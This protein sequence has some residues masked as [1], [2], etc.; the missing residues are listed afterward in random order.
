MFNFLSALFSKDEQQLDAKA[1]AN[2]PPHPCA[3]TCVLVVL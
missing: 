3:T 1:K 2:R